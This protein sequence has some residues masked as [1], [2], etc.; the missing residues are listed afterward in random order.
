MQ[1]ESRQPSMFER[2]QRDINVVALLLTSVS[3]T[4]EVFLRKRMGERSIGVRG[5]VG[6]VLLFV[7]G[8]FF[9]G[10]NLVP[11]FLFMWA[12]AAM[13]T[14]QRASALLRRRRGIREHSRYDGEPRVA[15]LAPK[16]DELRLKR[17][18]EPLVMAAV[19]LVTLALN[20]PLGTWFLIAAGATAMTVRLM[21][22]AERRRM[23]DLGDAMIEQEMRSERLR[24][25]RR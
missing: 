12:F 2:M 22:A 9:P 18:G 25:D 6:F 17:T 20:R 21:E 11:L 14:V 13:C 5:F 16:W 10:E 19:G 8:I 15:V 1:D 3:V 7:F 23:T 4:V 24:G